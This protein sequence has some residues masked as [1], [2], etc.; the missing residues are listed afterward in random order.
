MGATRLRVSSD[1]HGEGDIALQHPAPALAY[2]MA[3]IR[4]CDACV[5]RRYLGDKLAT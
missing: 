1:L 5:G 4:E 2:C 3:T